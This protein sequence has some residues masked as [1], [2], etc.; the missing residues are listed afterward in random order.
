ML[1]SSHPKVFVPTIIEVGK[2]VIFKGL[3]E[4]CGEA[5]ERV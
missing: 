3:T 2:L 1:Q 5:E 4:D